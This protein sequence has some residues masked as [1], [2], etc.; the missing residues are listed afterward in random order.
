MPRP[1]K[2]QPLRQNRERRDFGV[3]PAPNTVTVTPAAPRGLLAVQRAAWSTFWASPLAKVVELATD[4]PALTRLWTLY[5]ERERCYQG[6]RRERLTLGSQG[7]PVLNPLYRQLAAL[8]PEIRQLEDR[9]GLTPMSRLRLGVTFGDAAR[10]LA[11]INAEL[12][13]TEDLST[14]DPRLTVVRSAPADARAVGPAVDR[15]G[16]GTR[17]G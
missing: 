12:G 14:P 11:E 13:A 6:V 2:P 17:G 10:S 9:F 15:A 7:Q 4:L 8:D 16:T 5:D 1:P 3:I